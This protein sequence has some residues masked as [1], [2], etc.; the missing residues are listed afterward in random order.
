[1][2]IE[3]MI[4]QKERLNYGIFFTKPEIVNEINSFFNFSNVENVIDTAAG[5]CNFLI[6]LAKKYPHINFY[7]IEKNKRIYQEVKKDISNKKNLHY[8]HGDM[9]LDEFPIPKCDIYL[10]NPPFINF[11]DLNNKY[12]D[13]IKPSWLNHFPNA[14]GFKMLLGDSRGDIAQLIF[15][16]TIT[17][18]LKPHGKFGVVLPNS[19]IKGNSASAGFRE[20][21]NIA[22]EKIVDIGDRNPFDNTKRNC[23]YILGYKDSATNYPI[24]YH[25][26][27][28][29]KELVKSGS[30][31][32]I[33]GKSILKTS[34]YIA[35]QGVNTLGANGVFFFKKELPF[36]S[37]LFKPLLK[38]SDINSFNCTPSYKIL[39]PY[40]D[41]KLINED[42]LRDSHKNAYEYLLKNRSRLE[43]RKSRFAKQCWYT[44]FGIGD[45]TFSKYKVIWRGLGARELM[46][47]VSEDVIPNQA[48]NCYI[49]LENK[50]E[51]H[52][53][54]GVMNSSL[55]KSQ[56]SLLNESGA[57][58]FAQPSTINRLFIPKF[59]KKNNLHVEISSISEKMHKNKNCD[60]LDKLNCLVE[61]LYILHGFLNA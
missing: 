37:E 16:E 13:E 38:S 5:S 19:L 60:L 48:M 11:S 58:S 49:S 46:A 7:G 20:F 34:P 50:D 35:R 12:R 22:I 51:A 8:F 14:K 54:C 24:P 47:S 44:L 40:K 39:L 2:H 61:D 21:N 43:A 31:L 57:K 4:S 27:G 36:E 42:E 53:V 17:K 45:Y 10:G 18:Y 26:K 30:D 1:M 55:Y 23:F 25:T 33:K 41:G 6:P 29:I 59:N 32:I 3:D 9:I 15:Y 52:Y 56:L 28:G